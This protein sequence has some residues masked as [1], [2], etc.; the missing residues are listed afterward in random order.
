MH[1]TM[2]CKGRK[3]LDWEPNNL[4]RP[5]LNFDDKESGCLLLSALGAG[6][7]RTH[8]VTD[9]FAPLEIAQAFAP[10]ASCES[11]PP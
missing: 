2:A 3:T 5:D 1:Q 9:I 6:A 11:D 10:K 4:Q 8:Q 7:I